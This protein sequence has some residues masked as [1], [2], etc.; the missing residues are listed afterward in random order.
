[1][2]LDEHDY[3]AG[4]GS[5]PEVVERRSAPEFREHVSEESGPA[6]ER[7]RPEAEGAP[8]SSQARPAQP[9]HRDSKR[10]GLFRR[11][12]LAASLGVLA[13]ALVAGA[14]YL[15]WDNGS[16][17]ETTDD[18]FIAARQFAIAPQG[19]GYLTAVPV[20]DNQRV[21]AGQV[22]ARIDQRQYR[23]AL[24]QAEAQVAAAQA[25][26]ANIDAQTAV[27]QATVAQNEA[28]VQQQQA[29]L[30][31]AQQQASRYGTLAKDGWG[32]VQNAQQ[33]ASQQH[34]N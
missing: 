14:G 17:F 27:Q 32:T 25:S 31:F 22:I 26:I 20:T 18:A 9:P 29:G 1:M 28:Q 13:F 3:A 30:T 34:Q 6:P 7:L 12:P 24:E 33:W 4:S 8:A 16:H 2:P 19:S 23:I 15:Y 10:G 5:S 11:H 21:V